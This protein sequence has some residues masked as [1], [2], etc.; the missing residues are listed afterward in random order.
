M[1]ENFPNALQDVGREVGETRKSDFPPFFK[2]IESDKPGSLLEQDGTDIPYKEK[3]E[4][5]E[6][7]ID[8]VETGAKDFD[9]KN[10]QE[11]GNYGEMKTDQDLRSK[12]YERISKDM[13]TDI[14]E[15]GHHGLDGVYY[16]PEGEPQYLIVDAKYGT[17][18]LNET[19]KDGKQMSGNWIDRRMDDAVG[20]GKADEIRTEQLMNPDNVGTYVVHVDEKGATSFDRVDADGNIT[21]RNVKIA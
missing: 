3:V 1:V 11:T 10:T 8:A 7:E 6:K 5:Q 16:N 15:S 19:T 18:K 12:G 20:K 13:V 4:K 21:E 2:T 9:R 17:A 14:D